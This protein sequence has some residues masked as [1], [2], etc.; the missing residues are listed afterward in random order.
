MSC[1]WSLSEIGSSGRHSSWS[2]LVATIN[3]IIFFPFL[4]VFPVLSTFV[5][6][7]HRRS[8]QIKKSIYRKL[9]GVPKNLSRPCWSIWAPLVIFKDS[10]YLVRCLWSVFTWTKKT[11][12][13]PHWILSKNLGFDIFPDSVG[14]FWLSRRGGVAGSAVLQAVSECPR[15]R[16]WL[17]R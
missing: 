14:L 2:A 3:I 6:F 7:S 11:A 17:S 13:T 16:Y 1:N 15:R 12:Q 10:V 5:Y 8:T 9:I 4:P